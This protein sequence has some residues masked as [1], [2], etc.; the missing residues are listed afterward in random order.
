MSPR[1]GRSKSRSGKR[2]SHAAAQGTAR[3]QSSLPRRA[4]MIGCHGG[5][6][7]AVLSLLAQSAPGQHLASALDGL[8]LVDRD[9]PKSPVPLPNALLL[10]PRAIGST[11]DLV[12]LIREHR[13][14]EVL[15]LSSIDTL[16][17]ARACDALGAHFLCTSVE[18][19]PGASSAPTDEAI[20][21]LLPPQRPHLKRSHL[22][23]SGANPGIVNA[24]VFAALEEFG[25]R[26]GVAP[27]PAALDLHAVLITEEDT[28]IE[29]SSL[30]M[31]EDFPMT[32]SP[33]H[34][35]EELFERRAFIARSGRVESLGHRPIERAYRARCGETEIE[36]FA[37]PHEEVITLARKF[38]SLEIGFLYRIAPAAR[39]AL[40][41]HPDRELSQWRTR[42]LY[43]PTTKA[44][45]GEDRVGVLL[46]SRRYGE[47][48]MGFRTE[49]ASGLAYGTNA[50]QLQVAAGVLAGWSQLGTRAGIHFVEDLKWRD[51]LRIAQ[52]VLGPPLVV[53]DELAAP[54]ALRERVV[55]RMRRS[56]RPGR[57][58][59]GD[60]RL[61]VGSESGA[62]LSGQA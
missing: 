8:V 38:P 43:P 55:G 9:L 28:T 16:D 27:T 49:V 12:E 30:G 1:V 17:S 25:E 15:D 53:H 34:C 54:R 39:W 44:L 51:F 36:G 46:C 21:R 40:R 42:Q 3:M 57:L 26:V 4:L 52:Q 31:G 20:R 37:V 61:P 7:R 56:E 29:R 48:W 13:I 32:W 35:L 5:V 41:N 11:A 58:G 45:V 14:T 33:R 22:V 23:G 19:W 24:L 6:G 10:P 50:T 60:G 47:M 59:P 62:Y 18:E 2:P